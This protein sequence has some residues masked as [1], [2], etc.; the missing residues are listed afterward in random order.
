MDID[1][2]SNIHCVHNVRHLN[3]STYIVR[4]DRNNLK[5]NPGQYIAL[6][7]EG[8]SHRREYSIYSNHKSNYLEILVKKIIDGDVSVMLNK[9]KQ[10]DRIEVDGPFGFF[11]INEEEIKSKQFVFI[12]SGTGIAPFHSIIKSYPDLNYKLIHGV[13]YD[14]E[15]YEKHDYDSRKYILCTS[16][17]NNGD[18]NGRVTEYI[19]NFPV[20]S[21]MLFYICGNSNMIYDVYN[22]LM[23]KKISHKRIYTEV[24]F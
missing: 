14:N 3:E 13:R 11:T 6:G 22:I 5:F 17:S 16:K 18:F 10:N 20:K 21:N 1:I 7:P 12:A 4:F 9:C 8:T 19:K 23:K 24:Y 2:T 15:A